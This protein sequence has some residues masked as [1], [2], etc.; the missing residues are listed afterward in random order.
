MPH[1]SQQ[2]PNLALGPA[3][4]RRTGTTRQNV[5]LPDELWDA[6][7]DRATPRGM[8]AWIEQAVRDRL[9]DEVE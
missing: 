2:H 8:S 4:R 1:D 5:T 9:A 3:A 7:R 6:I